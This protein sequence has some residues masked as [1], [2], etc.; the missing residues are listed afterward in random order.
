MWTS[1]PGC[2]RGHF[3]GLRRDK[4]DRL[5]IVAHLRRLFFGEAG[6]GRKSL[7]LGQKGAGLVPTDLRMC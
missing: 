3:A 7:F 4:L 5:S 2:S 6:L 1:G